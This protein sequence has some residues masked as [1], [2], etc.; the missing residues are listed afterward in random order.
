MQRT[1][2]VVVR[3]AVAGEDN[4][5]MQAIADAKIMNA[6]LQNAPADVTL[7]RWTRHEVLELCNTHAYTQIQIQILIY[8][9]HTHTY[10]HT[11]RERDRER[12]RER[13]R[14]R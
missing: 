1:E 3:R 14:E 12:E 4:G 5:N 9:I 10:T 11:H 6:K 2:G 8:L 7:A 13:E